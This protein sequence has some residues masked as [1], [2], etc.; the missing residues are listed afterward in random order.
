MKT[1]QLMILKF[2]V[3]GF[4]STYSQSSELRGELMQQ[5]EGIKQHRKEVHQISF[6]SMAFDTSDIHYES[7]DLAY[8]DLYGDYVINLF[9][10]PEDLLEGE[11]YEKLAS[12]KVSLGQLKDVKVG[13]EHFDLFLEHK[14]VPEM[15]RKIIGFGFS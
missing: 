12:M 5:V 14:W 13:D 4:F 9:R 11:G 6:L 8:S 1:L 3:F 10:T 15:K 2:F 7:F